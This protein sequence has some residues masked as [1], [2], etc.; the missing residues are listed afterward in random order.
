MLVTFT[1]SLIECINI[2]IIIF[3]SW[4]YMRG[5]RNVFQ[6]SK[7]SP[8]FQKQAVSCTCPILILSSLPA[9]ADY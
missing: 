1:K 3:A 6:Q 8:N 9:S 4:L 2:N 5:S 7:L